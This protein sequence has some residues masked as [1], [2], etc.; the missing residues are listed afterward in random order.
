VEHLEAG[1]KSVVEALPEGPSVTPGK[2]ERYSNHQGSQKADGKDQV[3]EEMKEA[4]YGILYQEEVNRR[5]QNWIKE[6]RDS[7]YTRVIH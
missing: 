7:S 3:P 2:T 5:Y 6:L 4:I 1:L